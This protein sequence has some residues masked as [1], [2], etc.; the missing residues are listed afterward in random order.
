METQNKVYTAFE[1]REE[2][3][4]LMRGDMAPGESPHWWAEDLIREILEWGKTTGT[5]ECKAES[6]CWIHG[7]ET[8]EMDYHI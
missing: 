3:Q 4:A 1:L 2:I 8:D 6:Y 7:V 5:A